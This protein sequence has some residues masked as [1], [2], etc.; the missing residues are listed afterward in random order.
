MKQNLAKIF[1]FFFF[2]GCLPAHPPSLSLS[3]KKGK[4]KGKKERKRKERIFFHYEST[5]RPRYG[6]KGAKNG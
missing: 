6:K 2:F 3:L 5:C 1:Q 4:K